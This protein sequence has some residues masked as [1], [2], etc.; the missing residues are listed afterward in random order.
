MAK[1]LEPKTTFCGVPFCPDLNT[2]SA[3]VAV[4]GS[5]HGTPYQ[6]GV[7]SHAAGG[8]KAV[9]QALGWYSA[10]SRQF[11]LDVMA[12]VF[13][14]LTVVDCGDVDNGVHDGPANRVNISE[15]TRKILDVGTTPI[16][17]GG[18]DSVPIPFIE[19]FGQAGFT[20]VSIVQIDAHLDWRHEINGV[21]HGFSSTMR[22]VSEMDHVVNLIQ[23]GAR[24]P[25]SARQQEYEDACAWGSRIF[26]ARH[27]HQHGLAHVLEAV[28]AEAQVILSIDV[29]GLD[30]TLVPGV[31]LPAFGGLSYQ[32]ML[33]VIH[34]VADKA[35]IIGAAFVELVPENDPSGLGAQVIARL[36]SNVI[37]AIG[38]R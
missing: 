24:G 14:G 11:D 13:A 6:P 7:P 2:L 15:S 30:P 19:G 34:G 18:D 23:V 10:S 21:T 12:P 4:L 16:L 5:P 38:P 25:G 31:I 29:D 17:L 1:L 27:I 33:D 9:R 37:A 8:A 32:Q 28:P 35:R 36:I 26:S 3:D 22:R 20:E